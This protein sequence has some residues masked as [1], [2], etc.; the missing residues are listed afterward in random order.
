MPWGDQAGCMFCAA[1]RFF[2]P[3]YQNNL[4]QH[5]CPRSTAWSPSSRGG[6]HGGRRRLRPRLVDRDHGQGVPEQPASSA[7]TSMRR[8]SRT[9]A[10]TRSE[11]GVAENTRFEV[12]DGQGIPDDG[13]DLVTFFDCLHDMGDP[14]GAAAHVSASLKP[15]GTW[16]IVEPMAGDRLEDNLEPGRAALLRRLDDGLRADLAVAGG[17]RR[18]R[19]AGGRGEAARGHHRRRLQQRSPRD[20]DAVQHDPRSA[21]LQ[22]IIR[23]PPAP[24]GPPNLGRT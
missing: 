17:R 16:M 11:H 24:P 8:R 3:G 13:F 12:G 1:A 10:R 4:V 23:E 21:R 22:R 2:R 15:D 9:R 14:A 20:R 7:T 5:G 6:A 18:A 19:R